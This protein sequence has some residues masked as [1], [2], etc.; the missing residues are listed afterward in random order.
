MS[1]CALFSFRH[2][3]AVITG[4]SS[5]LGAEFARQL[6]PHAK[7]LLL[8]ARRGEVLAE[9]KRELLGIDAALQVV[10][11]A[12]DIA[13][14]EGRAE[15]VA[16]ALSLPEKPNLLINNAGAGDYG[17]F[18]TST[19]EKTR[20]Q[21]ELNMTALVMLTHALLPHMPRT[22]DAPAGIINVSSL[23]ASLPMPGLAIY[24]ATKAFVT[25][26]SEALRVELAG[27]N[28]IV[29]AVCPGPTPTNFGKNARRPDGTDTNRSG[30]GLVRIPPS[31]VVREAL[32][33]L[34]RDMATV[35]PGLGVLLASMIFRVMPRWIM[36]RL[37]KRRFR[38]KPVP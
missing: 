15:L 17:S 32:E 28:V 25:S 26:F 23:A 20:A 37:L 33:A 12:C 5:G 19:T 24:A 18:A 11:C 34:S 29:S 16:A 27:E 31:R 10:V 4:A 6:A 8:A 35:H 38:D 13:T 2:C 14:D 21:I 7:C 30:Q 1:S 3:T 9:V 36:R 22:A